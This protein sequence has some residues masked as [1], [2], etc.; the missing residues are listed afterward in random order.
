M[1]VCIVRGGDDVVEG[2]EDSRG[3]LA[4]SID[5]GE[6][7]SELVDYNDLVCVET[8]GVLWKELGVEIE[9]SSN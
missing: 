6:V 4:S 3:G 8:W 5:D 1:V 2:F 9:D 7:S